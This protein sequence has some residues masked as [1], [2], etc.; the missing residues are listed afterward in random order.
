[1]NKRQ[2]NKMNSYRDISGVLERH[3]KT[4]SIIPALVNCIEEF[5]SLVDEIGAVASRRASDTTGETAAKN[6][7]RKDLARHASKLAACGMA[8]AYDR[9]DIELEAALDYSYSEIEHVRDADA[10]KISRSIY[11]VLNRDLPGLDE[12][13]VSGDDLRE[14]ERLIS[15]FDDAM[16]LKGAEKSRRV[17]DTRA[18][19]S[20]FSSCD[21]L[22]SRKLDRLMIRMKEEHPRF[23]DSYFSARRIKDLH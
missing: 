11:K 15:R 21:S 23:H 16:V 2:S 17:A 22:L 6:M 3:R 10:L 8:Y 20:L 13:L 19:S 5:S 12:Y 9:A 1:M 4:W 18:L 7:A 14:L